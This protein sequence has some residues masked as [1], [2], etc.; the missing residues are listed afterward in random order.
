MKQEEQTCTKNSH[1]YINASWLLVANDKEELQILVF[2]SGTPFRRSFSLCVKIMD[3]LHNDESLC[4]LKRG[5]QLN[6]KLETSLNIS[7]L[8]LKFLT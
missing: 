8:T 1:I 4:F 2:L 5:A 6:N 7:N 3:I